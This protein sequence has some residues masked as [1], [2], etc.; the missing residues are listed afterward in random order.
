[1]R[2]NLSKYALCTT[3]MTLNYCQGFKHLGTYPKNPLGLLDKT[4]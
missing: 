1:M 4:T 2:S 3:T